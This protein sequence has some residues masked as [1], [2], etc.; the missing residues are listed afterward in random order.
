MILLLPVIIGINGIWIAV[1]AAESLALVVSV[2]FVII[3]RKK[4]GYM[5]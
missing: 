4:Y 5:I 3:N 2:V 1:T